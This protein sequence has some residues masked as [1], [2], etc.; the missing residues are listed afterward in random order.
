[1]NTDEQYKALQA[2]GKSSAD[3]IAE[4]VAALE[5]DY[6][7]PSAPHGKRDEPEEI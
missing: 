3:C 7:V 5:C 4:M 1:M 2:I 6:H